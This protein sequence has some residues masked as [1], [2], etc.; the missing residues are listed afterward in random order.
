MAPEIFQNEGSLDSYKEPVDVWAC[1]IML[2][3]LISAYYRFHDDDQAKLE[4]AICNDPVSFTRPC[5]S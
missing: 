1:G 5:F 2:Y 3:M 4:D